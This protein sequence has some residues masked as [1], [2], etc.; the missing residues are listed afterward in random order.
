MDRDTDDIARGWEAIKS[1]YGGRVILAVILFAVL[2]AAAVWGYNHWHQSQP[3]TYEPQQQAETPQGIQE[4]ADNAGVHIS[5]GQAQE[6]AQAI[7][8][9]TARPPDQIIHTTG[10]GMAQALADSRKQTRAQVQIVT[11]PEI[12]NKLPDKPAADQ[13]VALNVY[14]IKAYPKHLLEIT[15]YR[16]AV[17]AAYMTRVQVFG[18]TGYL[19]PVVSYDADRAGGKVRIGARLTIP[20]D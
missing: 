15:A 3:V 11:D 13:P 20:L 12:P 2:V 5:P 19:G 8:E 9:A 16:N 14:N 17:D 6:A 1:K 4:A 18:A 7:K 10:A